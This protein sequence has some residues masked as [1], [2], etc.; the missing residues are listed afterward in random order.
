M[1]GKL[2]SINNVFVTGGQFIACV[3]DALFAKVDYPH[4]W[5][6]MLGLAAAPAVVMFVGFMFLPESPRWLAQHKGEAQARADEMRPGR[7]RQD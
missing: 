7:A 3:V 2:V 5:R 1:R 4:G 6:W